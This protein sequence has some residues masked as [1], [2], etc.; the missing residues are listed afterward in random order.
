MRSPLPA[1]LGAVVTFSIAIAGCSA[2]PAAPPATERAASGGSILTSF[3]RLTLA[4]GERS[5]FRAS[6]VG[7]RARLSSAGLTFV[8][9]ASSVASVKAVN[10]RARVE[11][12][13]AGRTWILVQ[14][15]ATTDSVE[16]VVE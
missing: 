4:R 12:L 5:S 1:L 14:A 13:S 10:G 6:L 11:G 7:S 9:R 8:S 2:D 3:D 15:A 16:V